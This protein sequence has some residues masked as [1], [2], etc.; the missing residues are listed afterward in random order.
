MKLITIWIKILSIDTVLGKFYVEKD[1]AAHC[2][3]E[4]VYPYSILVVN[5]RVF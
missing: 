5:T 3:D 1:V 4:C 2:I